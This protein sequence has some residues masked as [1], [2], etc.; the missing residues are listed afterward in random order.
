MVVSQF[1][2]VGL[3]DIR[4][5]KPTTPILMKLVGKVYQ[6]PRNHMLDFRKTYKNLATPVILIDYI[7]II[8]PSQLYPP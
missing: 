4:I 6:W 1:V 8:L 7:K 3:S 5:H 2:C